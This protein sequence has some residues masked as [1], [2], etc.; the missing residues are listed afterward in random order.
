[1]VMATRSSCTPTVHE[2]T[3]LWKYPPTTA[4]LFAPFALL[5]VRDGLNALAMFVF[6]VTAASVIAVGQ[7]MRA[8]WPTTLA[9][10]LCACFASVRVRRRSGQLGLAFLLYP[11]GVGA[12]LAGAGPIR[13]VRG[14][15]S[16][17]VSVRSR[18]TH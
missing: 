11:D 4:F 8:R 2:P 5:S 12:L 13:S 6:T 10:A 15:P 1:M 9:L 17:G 7:W 18:A 3:C 14:S 16:Q